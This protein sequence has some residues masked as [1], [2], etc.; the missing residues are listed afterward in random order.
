M[1]NGTGV[2]V[3]DIDISIDT[4]GSTKIASILFSRRAVSAMLASWMSLRG[5]TDRYSSTLAVQARSAKPNIVRLPCLDFGK[6]E[7]VEEEYGGSEV[8]LDTD[9]RVDGDE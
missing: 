4:D 1:I 8:S 3:N 6:G 5:M 9:R 2:M 7:D